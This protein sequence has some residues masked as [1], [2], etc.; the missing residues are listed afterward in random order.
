MQGGLGLGHITSGDLIHSTSQGVEATIEKYSNYTQRLEAARW[1]HTSV[2]R[3]PIWADELLPVSTS[4]QKSEQRPQRLADPED[5]CHANARRRSA[6]CASDSA[7]ADDD[8]CYLQGFA[9]VPTASR[10]AFTGPSAARRRWLQLRRAASLPLRDRSGG[11][12]LPAIT[13]SARLR[14]AL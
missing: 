4:L 2:R 10:V 6:K 13:S 11:T 8:E 1:S 14:E 3:F 9:A 12:F 7:T 5:R